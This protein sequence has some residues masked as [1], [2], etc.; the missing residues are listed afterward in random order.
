[1]RHVEGYGVSR[2]VIFRSFLL[3]AIAAVYT[4]LLTRKRSNRLPGA[5]SQSDRKRDVD[6]SGIG[7]IES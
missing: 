3:I 2:M 1:M 6:G 4:M 5:V 7:A